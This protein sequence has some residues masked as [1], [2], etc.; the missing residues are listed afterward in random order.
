MSDVAGRGGTSSEYGVYVPLLSALSSPTSSSSVSQYM[1]SSLCNLVERQFLKESTIVFSVH[2]NR[3]PTLS[4]FDRGV[5]TLSEPFRSLTIIKPVNRKSA[6]RVTA[7]V[8][9]SG[10]PTRSREKGDHR[11]TLSTFLHLVTPMRRH[12]VFQSRKNPSTISCVEVRKPVIFVASDWLIGSGSLWLAIIHFDFSPTKR[13]NIMGPI[14]I[15]L[16]V[17]IL[18]AF[19]TDCS[20]VWIRHSSVKIQFICRSK[21]GHMSVKIW[22]SLD[23]IRSFSSGICFSV[24][25]SRPQ[26]QRLVDETK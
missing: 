19:D 11:S 14:V 1:C 24:V 23:R 18:Y 3:F 22:T 2:L 8:T 12:L 4:A 5:T 26:F 16:F 10:T 21:F 17:A 9:C 13:A 15:I 6:S 7:E 25:K 20:T